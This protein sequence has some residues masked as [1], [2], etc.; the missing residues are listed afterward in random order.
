MF[1]LTPGKRTLAVLTVVCSLT[2]VALTAF[3]IRPACRSL[4]PVNSRS[5]R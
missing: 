3:S 5:R 2:F 4:R 1:V